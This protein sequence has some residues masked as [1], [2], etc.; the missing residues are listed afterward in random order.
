MKRNTFKTVSKILMTCFIMLLLLTGCEEA[1]A[2]ELSSLSIDSNQTTG[3]GIGVGAS[4]D[5]FVGAY[6]SFLIQKVADEGNFEPFEIV[7]PEKDMPYET[8]DVVLMVSGFFVDEKPVSTEELKVMLDCEI[9]EV[10]DKLCDPEFLKEHKVIY[11]Y[12]IFTIQNN[13]VTDITGDYLDYNV[14]L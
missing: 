4:Y 13:T 5:E 11:K 8:E 12:V 9:D 3:A 10:A 2:P 14:E 6:G 7:K 1:V